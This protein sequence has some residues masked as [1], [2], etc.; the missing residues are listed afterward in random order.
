MLVSVAILRVGLDHSKQQ[1]H[2][3]EA[4]HLAGCLGMVGLCGFMACLRAYETYKFKVRNAT[5]IEG[6]CKMCWI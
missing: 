5:V 6:S 3:H 4:E 1:G 2:D